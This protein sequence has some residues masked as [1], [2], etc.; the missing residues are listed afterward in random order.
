MA[1]KEIPGRVFLDTCVVNFILDFGAQ[2]HDGVGA[3]AD[4]KERDAADIDA[5]YNLFLVG[6]RAVWQLAISPLTYVEIART[7]N[8]NRRS[9][10]DLWFQELWQYWRSTISSNNNL[11]SFIE[12][13]DL[14][15]QILESGILGI[16]PDLEDRVLLC[17][18]IVYHCD[19]FCTRD[20]SSIL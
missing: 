14:R 17:D 12:A 6:Q 8:K 18:A 20:W 2:I 10:L 7:R 3:P 4:I 1:A 19:L 15:A 5:F 16:L 9:K 13:E 11:P